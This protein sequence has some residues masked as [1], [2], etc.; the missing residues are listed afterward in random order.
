MKKPLLAAV[1]L[2]G[3]CA[4]CCAFPLLIPVL[5][6]L[7][8]GL[9]T[10]AGVGAIQI[11]GQFVAIGAGIVTALAVGVGIWHKRRRPNSCTLPGIANNPLPPSAC[12]CSATQGQLKRG[13]Q[14]KGAASASYPSHL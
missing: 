1:G 14:V 13:N 3:A 11:D 5:G 6:G 2:I 10:T 9:L 4:A 12:G 7:S 8:V